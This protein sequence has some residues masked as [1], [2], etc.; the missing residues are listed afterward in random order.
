METLKSV[1]HILFVSIAGFALNVSIDFLFPSFSNVALHLFVPCLVGFY[2]AAWSRSINDSRSS[3]LI[4]G[5]LAVCLSGILWFGFVVLVGKTRSGETVFTIIGFIIAYIV[6][7]SVYVLIG[8]WLR[9]QLQSLL[10]GSVGSAILFVIL[11]LVRP[12]PIV[13]VI[14][15]SSIAGIPLIAGFLAGRAA[16]STVSRRRALWEAMMTTSLAGIAASGVMVY[17]FVMINCMGED[18]A[19][20]HV[21]NVVMH[22]LYGLYIVLFLL[23]GL[24]CGLP[25]ILIPRRKKSES[26][27]VSNQPLI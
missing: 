9:P 14:N 19:T 26:I 8:L 21:E 7:G 24:I 12:G 17:S 25:A 27:L 4:D 23:Y 18:A 5:F 6:P 16:L 1:R 13:S 2:T 11:G 20:C 3:A 15:T 10:Y 22:F